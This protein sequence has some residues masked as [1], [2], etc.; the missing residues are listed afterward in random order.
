M[1]HFYYF[2]DQLNPLSVNSS[3]FT[4]DRA[5]FNESAITSLNQLWRVAEE[6]DL[7]LNINYG[8]EK[9]QREREMETEYLFVDQPSIILKDH[10]SQRVNWHKL[11]NELSFTANRSSYFL[12]EKLNLN[13]HW[14]EALADIETNQDAIRQKLVLPRIH[15]KNSLSF[16]KL[17]GNI[18][19]GAGS[20]TEFTRLPQSLSIVS[21]DTL[22][23]FSTQ[24]AYQSVQFNDGFSDTF[25]TLN[26]KKRNHSIDVKTGA[27]WVW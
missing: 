5:R 1:F 9:E 24:S 10:T 23:L 12:K 3:F 26:Y 13:F 25:F 11:E 8:F 16:S 15:I 19:I 2:S 18:S 20:N 21:S 22:P 4:R 17:I 14:K 7:R 6:S 27:E